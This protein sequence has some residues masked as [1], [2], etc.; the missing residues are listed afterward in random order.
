MMVF[1][2]RT[3]LKPNQAMIG[4]AVVFISS[5]PAALVKVI[6]PASSGDMPKPSC[7]RSASRNGVEP[8]AMR[9]GVPPMVDA[10]NDCMR[11]R[12]RSRMACGV[13]RACHQ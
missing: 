13:R 3:F 2:T 7:R 9:S 1:H 11:K 5:A 4:R 12:E 6:N 8:I 10:M